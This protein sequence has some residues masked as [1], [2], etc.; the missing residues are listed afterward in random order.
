MCLQPPENAGC[1]FLIGSKA[2][3]P[4]QK[5]CAWGCLGRFWVRASL[6][7]P[8]GLDAAHM[9]SAVSDLAGEHAGILSLI[10]CSPFPYLLQVDNYPSLPN[11]TH[12]F[13]I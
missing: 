13:L 4:G 3:G 11:L 8:C 1:E 10:K 12:R 5:A 6:R 2:G 9:G 7:C